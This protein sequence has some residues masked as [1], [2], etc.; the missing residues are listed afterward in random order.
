MN[1]IIAGFFVRTLKNSRA[2]KLKKMETQ[3][4][5]LKLKNKYS[6]SGIF[7]AWFTFSRVKFK[8]FRRKNC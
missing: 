1:G 4:K 7:I 8:C 5:N 3:E 2:P 6:F